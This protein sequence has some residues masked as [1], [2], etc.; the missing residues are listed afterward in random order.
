MSFAEQEILSAIYELGG[1]DA[2][3]ISYD[4]LAVRLATTIT[5][6]KTIAYL[7]QNRRLA[8]VTLGGVQLTPIGLE[9]AKHERE[10]YT[11]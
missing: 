11:D 2:T 3:L 7:L 5:A 4:E 1:G 10:V 8:I 6:V 9:Q